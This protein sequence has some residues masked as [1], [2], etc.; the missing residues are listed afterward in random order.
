[1]NS[2]EEESYI[3]MLDTKHTEIHLNFIHIKVG[4]GSV[5]EKGFSFFY[6]VLV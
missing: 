4:A 2:E 1:M 5:I 6:C 3:E